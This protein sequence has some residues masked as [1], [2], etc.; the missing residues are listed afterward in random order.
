MTLGQAVHHCHNAAKNAGWWEGDVCIPTK[1]ALV[2]SELSEA[3]EGARKDL[4]DDKL[5]HR[6]ML[7]VELADTAIRFFDLCGA[8]Y[9]DF[10]SPFP[11]DDISQKI[12]VQRNATVGEMIAS[13]HI[14]LGEWWTCNQGVDDEAICNVITSIFGCAKECGFDILA[15]IDEKMAFNLH[16]ED[17]KPE[18]RAGVG[19]KK[20]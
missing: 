11:L 10:D 14:F 4:M 3:L 18:N 1:Y 15:A 6:K 2:H 9:E 17:H 12:E 13:C 19:G 7:E 20:F 5:P 16:R 8:I